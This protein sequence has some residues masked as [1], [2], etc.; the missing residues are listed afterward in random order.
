[1]SNRGLAAATKLEKIKFMQRSQPVFCNNEKISAVLPA[2]E[3]SIML[4]KSTIEELAIKVGDVITTLGTGAVM[5]ITDFD[6]SYAGL[7]SIGTAD[8]LP[9]TGFYK[10][11]RNGAVVTE[12][13]P[14]TPHNALRVV[15]VAF[16]V[17]AGDVITSNSNLTS[18]RV[19][20]VGFLS[21]RLEN[22]QLT[23]LGS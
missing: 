6:F 5:L 1:M 3:N 11:S 13:L 14:I 4:P 10:H 15:S 22:L 20:A 2:T 16:R 9:N 8:Y 12:A 23:K 18:Y 17:K 7:G 19:D 21:P